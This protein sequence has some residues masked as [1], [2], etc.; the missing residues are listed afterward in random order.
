M[1]KKVS[2]VLPVFNGEDH[3]RRSI[4]SCLNQTYQNVE[5]ILVNDASTDGTLKVLNEYSDRALIINNSRNLKLPKSLNIGH[6]VATG[7]LCTWTS[8]DNFY[9]L[10]AIERLVKALNEN[11]SDLVYSNFTNI[12]KNCA[13]IGAY[14]A[15]PAWKLLYKNVVG[16]SFLYKRQLFEELGGFDEQLFLLEDYDFWRRAFLSGAKLTPVKEYL[17]FYRR[18]TNSLTAK[19]R[20]EIEEI[21]AKYLKESSDG[22]GFFQ[23]IIVKAYCCMR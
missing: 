16:A 7:E 10:N 12:D 17:Y 4:E 2:I 20:E 5:L 6:Q 11:K 3:V 9:G 23:S 14:E 18:H 1:S 8:H 22:L 19:R 21:K 13:R 15:E